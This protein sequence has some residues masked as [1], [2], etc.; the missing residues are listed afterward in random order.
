MEKRQILFCI[1]QLFKGGAETALVN[2]L[3]NLDAEKYD[4]DLLIFDQINVP[5]SVDLLG[6]VPEWVNVFNAAEGENQIAY[7]KKSYYRIHRDITKQQLFRPNAVQYVKRKRYD[8][9]ISYGEWFS[10]VLVAKHA[11]AVRKYLWIHSDMD[12]A[13]FV[14]PDIFEHYQK[15]DRIIFVSEESKKSALKQYPLFTSRAV[16]VHNQTNDK[17][18][19]AQSTSQTVKKYDVPVLVTV[20]NIRPEKNHIRQVEAM[21]ILK[22][23]GVRFKW[24]NI[25]NQ[26]AVGHVQ[27]LK[28][29]IREAGLEE[30]FLIPG[31]M[32]NPYA[33][34][35]AA[36]AV[37]VLSDHESWSMVITEAKVLGVPV[38]A[39]ATSGAIEQ[40]RDNETGILCEFSAEAIADKIQ[41]F[42]QTPELQNKIRKNLQA[43]SSGEEAMCQLG[44]LLDDNRKKMLYV[45]DDI[46]YASGARQAALMQL[47]HLSK[48]KDVT[49]FTGI[50]YF[51]NTL[52]RKYRMAD[53]SPYYAFYC[54][55]LSC[56][57][58]LTGNVYGI[59]LKF[60]RLVYAALKRIGAG[61]ALYRKLLDHKFRGFM[62]SFDIICVM[63][64]GSQFR[65]LVSSMKNPKKVQW[66]HTDYVSWRKHSYWT[67]EITAHDEK[68]YSKYDTVIC[69]SD[70]LAEKFSQ[71]YPSLRDKVVAVPNPVN[72]EEILERANK[73]TE[74]WVKK[75]YF[76]IITI[77]RME[78]EKRYD[79]LLDIAKDLKEQGL[80]FRW[81]FVGDGVLTDKIKKL[82]NKLHL[83]KEVIL[84]GAM[85]NP[86]ALLKACDVMVLMSEYEGTPVTI[87]EA[88]VLGVP[89]LAGN[90][91][92]IADQL[93]NHPKSAVV[94]K[95]DKQA[96]V[97]LLSDRI[98]HRTK[99]CAPEEN[100][101]AFEQEQI[102]ILAKLDQVLE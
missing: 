36:D 57:D 101:K 56:K 19:R 17:G 77:G 28:K 79:Y 81:Y 94:G 6:Q 75:K 76:T 22:E 44:P 30:D 41:N 63:S 58:V 51:G 50:P 90:V 32:D 89:V 93:K 80:A 39:T 78:N 25:G 97:K 95:D 27:K 59:R 54:L 18:I 73:S 46:N 7:L 64:E 3:H 26:A 47:D 84:T 72:A 4:V 34:M 14:Y 20:A 53:L 21:R 5:G 8:V 92:G 70:H 52:N 49:I 12:K 31:A 62:E 48:S 13:S 9:A 60:L 38:I 86:C 55:T 65:S 33:Q 91:G 61:Q 99:Y 69:L 100:S 85:K 10:S 24:I 74:L 29:A 87:E 68:L 96:M 1:N 2:L 43:F 102:K 88:K 67:R 82:R 35:K 40:I 15:F 66:I 83:K 42:I 16:V 71:L 98:K 11:N 37:C 45:F 23:R